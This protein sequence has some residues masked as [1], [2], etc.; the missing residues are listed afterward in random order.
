M[1]LCVQFPQIWWKFPQKTQSH[2]NANNSTYFRQKCLE[3]RQYRVSNSIFTKLSPF[4]PQSNLSQ[5]SQLQ[6][7]PIST[8]HPNTSLF[9][10]K[11]PLAKRV[12]ASFSDEFCT[13]VLGLNWKRS[14][15]RD[16]FQNLQYYCFWNFVSISHGDWDR[17]L[18]FCHTNPRCYPMVTATIFFHSK[19]EQSWK[20]R[21]SCPVRAG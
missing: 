9:S 21:W 6:A 17:A 8:V 2:P 13:S 5:Q 15:P 7:N 18:S 1:S 14:S 11:T 19:S 12:R 16:S 3:T 4:Y 10:K 20:Y